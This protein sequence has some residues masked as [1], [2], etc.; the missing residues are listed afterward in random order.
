MGTHSFS[1]EHFGGLSKHLAYSKI[2]EAKTGLGHRAL[3]ITKAKERK[4]L[5]KQSGSS[6]IQAAIICVVCLMKFLRTKFC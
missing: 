5:G 6:T 1:P 2:G 4:S 3:V